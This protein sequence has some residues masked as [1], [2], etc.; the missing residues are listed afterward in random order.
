[1]NYNQKLIQRAEYIIE[2]AEQALKIGERNEYGTLSA[3]SAKTRTFKSS[4]LSFI[5]DLYGKEHP[6][7]K[8]FENVLFTIL[9]GVM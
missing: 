3:D 6:Y 5:L 7:Y 4:G 1:M 9:K 2:Q 8:E